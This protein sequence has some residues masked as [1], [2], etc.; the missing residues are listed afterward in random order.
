MDWQNKAGMLASLTITETR[1][2]LAIY[3][4]LK[5]GTRLPDK[6]HDTCEIF[7]T[8]CKKKLFVA[9]LKLKFN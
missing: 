7:G 9:Y 2:S 1:H 8:Y 5:P 4:G 6:I 3:S